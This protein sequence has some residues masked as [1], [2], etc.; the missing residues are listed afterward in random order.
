MDKLIEQPNTN[1]VDYRIVRLSDGSI[2]VGSISIDKEFLR[3]QN[4][5]ELKS[6]PRITGNGVKEDSVLQPWMPFTEDKL[7]VIPKEKVMVIS[8]AAK[9]LANY[10]EV[11]LHKLSNLKTKA[12][13]SPAEIER[14]MQIADD[15]E[16]QLKEESEEEQF[17]F[18][19]RKTVH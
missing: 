4:P 3:I 6:T 9:E 12:V 8:K 11:I 7:F 16:A 14:I 15:M 19:E 18:A 2:L 13:Y 17:D 1:I 10:Y 5:L